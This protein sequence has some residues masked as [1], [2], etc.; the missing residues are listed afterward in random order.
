MWVRRIQK[1]NNA[2]LIELNPQLGYGGRRN[3]D[4]L[5]QLSLQFSRSQTS[6]KSRTLLS[7][8]WRF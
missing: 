7:I 5:L 2:M 1:R 4:V 8:L 3:I 6:P